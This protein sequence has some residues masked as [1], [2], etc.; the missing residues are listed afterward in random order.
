MTLTSFPD[1]ASWWNDARAQPA[2]FFAAAGYYH[3]APG[4]TLS[5]VVQPNYYSAS[6][7]T[8]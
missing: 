6:V 3:T 1:S 7:R 2:A 8:V 5:L 4:S